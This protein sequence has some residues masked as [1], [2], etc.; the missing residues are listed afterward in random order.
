MATIKPPNVTAPRPEKQKKPGKPVY[1][2]ERP[3]KTVPTD[4]NSRKYK[5]IVRKDFADESL[6]FD[7]MA[8]IYRGRAELLSKRAEETRSMGSREDRVKM[9]RLRTMVERMSALTEELK[10]NGIDVDAMLKD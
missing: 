5:P 2:G 8:G 9:R 4:W 3:L 6:Y 1:P 10:K 7:H